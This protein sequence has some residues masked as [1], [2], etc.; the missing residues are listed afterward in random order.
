M[1]D[2]DIDVLNRASGLR[3]EYERL[4]ELLLYPEVASDIKLAR[5]YAERVSSLESL[6]AALSSYE[7]G[8]GEISDVRGEMLLLDAA[9]YSEDSY[10]GAGVCARAIYNKDNEEGDLVDSLRRYRAPMGAR[11]TVMESSDAFLR[12]ECMGDRVYAALSAMP[13]GVLP[14]EWDI[15]V[16]PVLRRLLPIRESDVRV[17]IFNS[18]GKGGQNINRVETAVRLTHIPTGVTV[19]CQDERSQLQNKKRAARTLAER[20]DKYY[21]DAQ[22]IL[23]K[24]ARETLYNRAK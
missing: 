23:I 8:E 2:M 20:V 14:P 7:R 18:H 3:E 11:V 15:A 22:A 13:R 17:D 12:L 16:Y 6:L 4:S 9:S 21:E 1:N 10:V 24:K 19:T 5:H